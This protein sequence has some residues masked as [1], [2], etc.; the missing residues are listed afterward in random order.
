MATL[1]RLSFA[2]DAGRHVAAGMLKAV[3]ALAFW[4]G[5]TQVKA[6]RMTFEQVLGA[7]LAVFY[8][9]FGAAQA[10]RVHWWVRADTAKARC[11]PWSN[12]STIHWMGGY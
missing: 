11:S 3:A 8:A 4:F 1:A 12:G 10:R 2:I 5:W 9:A 6:G 7:Y